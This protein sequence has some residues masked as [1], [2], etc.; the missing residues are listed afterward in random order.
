MKL[1]LRISHWK[2]QRKLRVLKWNEISGLGAITVYFF[3]GILT[4]FYNK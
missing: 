3:I 2:C 4:I 1:C